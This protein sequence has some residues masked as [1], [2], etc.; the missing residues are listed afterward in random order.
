IRLFSPQSK[1]IQAS[2]SETMSG[3]IRSPQNEDTPVGP[4][5][6]YGASKAAAEQLVNVYKDSYN[7]F[8]CFSRSFNHT[9]ERRGLEFVERKITNYVGRLFNCAERYVFTKVL[10]KNVNS[11][12]S[13]DLAANHIINNG[14]FP[15]LKLGNV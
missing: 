13:V 10:T 4:R 6:P 15:K 14:L 3:K 12:I 2:T 7:L 1:F 8:A 11:G 9:S 5:S